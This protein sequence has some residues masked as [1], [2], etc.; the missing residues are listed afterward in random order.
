[1]W[2]ASG[3][4]SPPTDAQAEHSVQPSSPSVLSGAVGGRG[5]QGEGTE[6]G[7]MEGWR[8]VGVEEWRE[9]RA[10]WG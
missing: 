4:P 9:G 3:P 5:L 7:S 8:E 6:E 1:M 2:T 10:L